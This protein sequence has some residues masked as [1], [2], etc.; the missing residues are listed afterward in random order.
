MKKNIRINE[1][2]WPVS[3]NTGKKYFRFN[4]KYNLFDNEIIEQVKSNVD[5]TLLFDIQESPNEKNPSKP[6]QNIRTLGEPENEAFEY[7]GSMIVKSPVREAPRVAAVPMD[8]PMA[9]P[10]MPQVEIKELKQN[11]RVFGKGDDQVKLYFLDEKDLQQQVIKLIELDLMPAAYFD[12]RKKALAVR[13]PQ[14]TEAIEA[15]WDKQQE[16]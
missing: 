10:I 5:N 3:R 12:A 9:N 6:F 13:N 8:K 2:A 1:F 16:I 11:S 15:A 4:D 7:D 14:T